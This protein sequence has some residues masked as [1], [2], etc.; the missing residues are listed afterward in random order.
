MAFR[1]A[2]AALC[3]LTFGGYNA[4]V[5]PAAKC[6]GQ[7]HGEDHHSVVMDHRLERVA[8]DYEINK[9]AHRGGLTKKFQSYRLGEII[10]L[11]EE[12]AIFRFLFENPED[13]FFLLPCSTLQA[14]NKQGGMQCEN[15]QRMYTPITPVGTK[16][17]FDILVKKMPRGRMTEHLFSMQVGES[18]QFKIVNYKLRYMP[19]VYKHVGMIGTGSG[20]TPLLQVIRANCANKDDKTKLTLLFANPS[21]HRVLLKGTLD[22]LA[23][24]SEGKFTPYYTVDKVYGPEPWQGFVGYIN[25]AMVKKT[26]PPPAEGNIILVCGSD[27]LMNSIC[28]VPMEVM[29]PWSSGLAYQ[30]GGV[31]MP[32]NMSNQVN[33]T[34][35]RLG[36]TSEQ[37]YRF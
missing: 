19:N 6:H 34:L 30:P 28:G 17:Y 8:Q 1:F 24:Q 13:E 22:D 23:K 16:G 7:D 26:M 14:L 35:G 25:D 3:G 4:F 9:K 11:S 2:T 20:I 36:Y 18:L 10:N 32:G 27:R 29:K 21:D 12:T 15:V 37:V 5:K 33:G 31:T